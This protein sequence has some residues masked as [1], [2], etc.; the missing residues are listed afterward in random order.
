[1]LALST[2]LDLFSLMVAQKTRLT[3]MTFVSYPQAL[4]ARYT[5]FLIDKLLT[6][7]P[8][9]EV[10]F[11]LIKL[12]TE[13]WS[14]IQGTD[15]QYC[16]DFEN[17]AN[18]VCIALAKALATPTAPYLIF[19]MPSLTEVDASN[20]LTSSYEDNPNLRE[21]FLSDDHHR[22]INAIDVLDFSKE[23]GILKNNSL[24]YGKVDCLSA[25]ETQCLLSR[26]PSVMI[27]FNALQEKTMFMRHGAT[28]GAALNRLI[29][30]LR[31]GGRK[32]GFSEDDAGPTAGAAI[33]QF[34]DYLKTIDKITRKSILS[35]GKYDRY[36]GR[37]PR[38]ATV[39][40]SWGLLINR[41]YRKHTEIKYC[42]ELIAHRL[43]EILSS[44]PALWDIVSCTGNALNEFSEL[45]RHAL[46]SEIQLKAD[47]KSVRH[48]RFYGEKGDERLYQHLILKILQSDK[49]FVLKEVDIDFLAE[50]TQQYAHDAPLSEC[51]SV[52]QKILK[53][54][55]GSNGRALCPQLQIRLRVSPAS[56]PF[57]HGE[58]EEATTAAAP[59]RGG[60]FS[61]KRLRG[62]NAP[63]SLSYVQS[64]DISH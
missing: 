8:Y 20:Y 25:T 3:K 6:Q 9:D 37:D 12:L 7:K 1:M 47:I 28:A 62:S 15:A 4:E 40:E 33:V 49:T 24:F 56:Q 35:A 5:L 30:G 19:L 34:N 58:P 32:N 59:S 22:L 41:Q 36:E 2:V 45:A 27:A 39:R 52:S 61:R 57:L 16:H 10:H 48:H 26:H 63:D 42:V 13:R 53:R 60:L 31:E 14:R 64:V 44:N 46:T 21:C 38:L 11:P 23:D 55:L 50:K 18:I 17:P 51:A 29:I 43:E 54:V